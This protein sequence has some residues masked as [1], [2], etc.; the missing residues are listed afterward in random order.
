[1][2]SYDLHHQMG[3][4]KDRTS[5]LCVAH[6]ARR[7]RRNTVSRLPDSGCHR[8]RPVMG[9]AGGPVAG[10]ISAPA[11]ITGGVRYQLR[12]WRQ[13][14]SGLA[15][16]RSCCTNWADASPGQRWR[17]VH[18]SSPGS[19]PASSLISVLT[20]SHCLWISA[21]REPMMGMIWASSEM[22]S[23]VSISTFSA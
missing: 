5:F 6:Y 16:S 10:R 8:R 22:H 2:K 7:Q 9:V 3:D 14:L 17:Y 12:H 4:R 13:S 15:V 21:A 20:S 1:M 19:I 18:V 23:P 11:G